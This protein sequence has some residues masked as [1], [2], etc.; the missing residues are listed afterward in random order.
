M[1]QPRTPLLH[2]DV[3]D[4]ILAVYHQARHEF[5]HGFLEILCQRVMVIAL[6]QA[7]LEVA[8]LVPCAVHFRGQ[9]IGQLFFDIVVNGVVLI[10]VKSCPHLEPRHTA[11]VIN[12]LRASELEVGLLL[13]FGPKA[14]FDRLIFSNARKNLAP[15]PPSG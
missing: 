14:E 13:N 10:E 11:Q 1:P 2:G 8:Q 3:T 4:A 9:K 12:Y 15:D 6:R 5:G 7:G